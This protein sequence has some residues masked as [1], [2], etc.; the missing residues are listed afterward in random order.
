MSTILSNIVQNTT[1]ISDEIIAGNMLASGKSAADAYLNATITSTTPELRALY[2]SS[3]N[4]VVGG[5]SALTEL[6][7]NK[8]WINPY[9]PPTQQLSDMVSKAEETVK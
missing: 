8:G 2:S 6:T 4:Q 3:L 5:H 7:V 1:D 9:N